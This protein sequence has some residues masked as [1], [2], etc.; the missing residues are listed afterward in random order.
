M[1]AQI[2]R[3]K[4]DHGPAQRCLSRK[5]ISTS[6]RSRRYFASTKNECRTEAHE[7]ATVNE[8]ALCLVYVGI[9]NASCGNAKDAIHSINRLKDVTICGGFTET[10]SVMTS[11]F[12][13]G[14]YVY[15]QSM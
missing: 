14:L 3:R 8:A 13:G 10:T 4:S 5:A 6:Q 12:A 9:S 15:D 1:A 7:P 2:H 11:P